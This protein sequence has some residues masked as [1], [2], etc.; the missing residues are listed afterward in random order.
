MDWQK[1]NR[2]EV[3]LS[4]SSGSLVMV[5]GRGRRR[6]VRAHNRPAGRRCTPCGMELASPDRFGRPFPIVQTQHPYRLARPQAHLATERKGLGAEDAEL[7]HVHVG[8]VAGQ[9]DGL[10]RG[11]WG[12]D[13]VGGRRSDRRQGSI[14][15]QRTRGVA[16]HHAANHTDEQDQGEA[17]VLHQ[18]ILRQRRSCR[19]AYGIGAA[20]ASAPIRSARNYD[21]SE[22]FASF[23]A[24]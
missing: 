9:Q 23:I 4:Q 18:L 14:V 2:R 17:Q 1:G 24:R 12:G 13:A 20:R 21:S 16:N 15:R 19:G 22:S 8:I 3:T 7:G 11:R 5:L 6:R 10:R